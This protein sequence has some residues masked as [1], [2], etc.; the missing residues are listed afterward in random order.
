MLI[1]KLPLSEEIYDLVEVKAFRHIPGMDGLAAK[2]C[3]FYSNSGLENNLYRTID[4]AGYFDIGY[5]VIG[6]MD[7]Y[8]SFNNPDSVLDTLKMIVHVHN[9]A[10][11]SSGLR[12]ASIT[13]LYRGE[14]TYRPAPLAD[15]KS[16]FEL[17][18]R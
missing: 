2:G 17:E 4:S 18:V 1:S 12:T 13:A 9:G 8:Y 10:I 14:K 6:E 11:G 15:I 7:L 5:S 16:S 3:C